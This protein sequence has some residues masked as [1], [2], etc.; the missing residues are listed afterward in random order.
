MDQLTKYLISELIDGR[1]VTAIYGGEF[2][3]PTKEHFNLVKKTL[4]DNK[5]I[6][7]VI[8]Y[9]GDKTEEGITQ[10]QSLQVWGLFKEM[11]GDKIEIIPSSQPLNDIETYIKDNPNDINIKI[12]FD[13]GLDS[14]DARKALKSRN[15]E[16]FLEYLPEEMPD[17]EKESVW[18]IFEDV[19][20]KEGDP[21]VGTGKKPKGSSR[22]LYTDEDPTDTVAIK[23]SS[24]QDIID[25]LSKTSFKSKP[26]NRQSQIINVI[27]QRVRAAYERA[28]DPEVKARLKKA[29]DY[30]EE[31]KEISKEKTQR[32]NKENIAPNHTGKAAPYGSGYKKVNENTIPS[33]NIVQKCA[34]LTQH[35][36]DKGYN[37]QPLPSVKFIS[38]DTSNAEDFLGRTAYY[39]PGKKMIVLYTYGR[40]PKDIVR[41]FAHEM[42]HHM[43]NLEGRLGDITTTDTTEDDRLNDLE[44]EA[45]LKGTM[46]FRNWTDS[47]IE[48]KQINYTNP[49]FVEEWEEAIRYP[50]FK[51]MGKDG[52][53][54]TANQGKPVFYSSIKDKLG[55]VDLDFEG[56]E[57]PKKQRFLDALKKGTIEMP[58]AI[59]FSNSDYDL[60]AGNTRLSGLIKNGIDP[61][62]WVIDISNLQEDGQKTSDKNMDDYLKKIEAEA[63][64]KGTMTF[65]NWTDSL[66]ESFYLD[67]PKFNQ[68]KTTQQ[69]LIE[70][71]NEISLSKENAV[72]IDG[73]L[74][75]GTFTV[76]DI[77]YEYS[78]KNIPNP[79]KDLGLFYNVQFTPRGEV[80]SIPKGGKENY[81]KI[82]STM[83][84]I[85]VDFI[86]K[87]QP[88]YIGISSLDNSRDKNY[89]TIYNR[90]TNNNLNLIPGYFRKD[91]SLQFDSP[92]G[93]G[94]FIV[95][96]RKDLQEK[97]N[98]DP[99]GLNQFARELAQGLEETK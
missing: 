5:Q 7:K 24:K 55:N 91:S 81:I 96:K 92:Q 20:L 14:K 28:K 38:D 87:E 51:E 6:D 80:T 10:E 79:Y 9:V 33:I 71:I 40:H 54:K 25:T 62:I 36:I 70:T 72:D 22:R 76:G 53:L 57:E 15:K 88:D 18:S 31:R 29:L 23:F 2:K 94:R 19:I 12:S 93:K 35:M 69:Y 43:Q 56:L 61:K 3:P 50:E 32:L 47:I 59:K 85:I 30:A 90:L 99:F 73:D 16:K 58:I 83:Y 41:S 84:K 78:I 11:L 49:N 37:I 45:N 66:S 8:V 1:K 77:T 86:D 13:K 64:L 75:G 42:I 17:T 63:N 46:T 48:G 21:K 65:R 60:V 98:K 95:L 74:A 67:I 68:P 26:H 39:N 27:H 52:W 97:K 82:L 44:K 89:H 4:K 34:E